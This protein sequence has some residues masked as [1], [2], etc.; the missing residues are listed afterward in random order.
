MNNPGCLVLAVV[1]VM[2]AAM[3]CFVGFAYVR[4]V[5]KREYTGAVTNYEFAFPVPLNPRESMDDLIRDVVVFHDST[6]PDANPHSVTEHLRR[7]AVELSERPTD[8]EEI[9]DVFLLTVAAAHVAGLDLALEVRS[10]LEIN[11]RRK[12]GKPDAHGV[13]EHVKTIMVDSS[14]VAE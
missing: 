6:F 11:K 4:A 7:E 3:N 2:M 1:V 14:E 8:G 13:I 12:W 10:K 9:A 5:T